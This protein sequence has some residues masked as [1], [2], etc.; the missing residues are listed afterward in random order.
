MQ[1]SCGSTAV[2]TTLA[3]TII[4]KIKIVYC[5]TIIVGTLVYLPALHTNG[6]AM[7]TQRWNR[8]RYMPSTAKKIPKLSVVI[9]V[10]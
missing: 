8:K 4:Y 1:H 5:S 10:N 9:F 6:R 2:P 7:I 3:E